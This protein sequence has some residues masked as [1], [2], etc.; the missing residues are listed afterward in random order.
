MIWSSSNE[1]IATVEDGVVTPLR[2]GKVNITAT[3]GF[4]GYSD[5]ILLNIVDNSVPTRVEIVKPKSTRL[6]I[7]D[8]LRLTCRIQPSEADKTVQWVSSDNTVA[9]VEDGLVIPHRLG[10]VKIS[11]IAENGGKS[12]M[13]TL[14]ITDKT[15]PTGITLSNRTTTHLKLTQTLALSYKLSPS[16]ARSSVTW[17]SN[18]QNVAT[19]SASGVVTPHRAGTAK[20]TATTNRGGKSASVQVIVIDNT[21]PTSIQLKVSNPYVM[22]LSEWVT[23]GYTILPKSAYSAVTWKSNYPKVASVDASTGKVTAHALGT[24]TITATTVRGNRKASFKVKVVDKHAPVSIRFDEKKP[25]RLS[26]GKT[27]SLRYTIHT[28]Y[29]GWKPNMNV[30]FT[31]NYP[32]VVRVTNSKKGTIQAMKPG[33]ATITVRTDNGKTAKIRVIVSK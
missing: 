10:S 22:D 26:V 32:S 2:T 12:D 25:L 28:G 9:T 8:T 29:K 27:W 6:D 20:I 24:A 1:S 16:T 18:N 17:S 15:I 7:S 4:G 13:I 21:L 11:A 14:T 31:S 23:P 19:V 33:S 5:T 3:T 30:T